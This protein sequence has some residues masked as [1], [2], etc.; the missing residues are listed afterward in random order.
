MPRN[1]PGTEETRKAIHQA[2]RGWNLSD[3][4]D[5]DFFDGFL[6]LRVSGFRAGLT[7]T[8]KRLLVKQSI[9]D[10]LGQLKE[11]QPLQAEILSRRFLHDEPAQQIALSVSVSQDHLNRRQREAIESLAQIWLEKEELA[12]ADQSENLLTALPPS[13]YERLF[14]TEQIQTRLLDLLRS[15]KANWLIA[16]TG[17]GGIGKTA[18]ADSVVRAMLM[19]TL[20]I[21]VIWLR[22]GAEGLNS[23]R[24]G[25]QLMTRL[26][27]HFS[28]EDTPSLKY[29]ESLR[30][31]FKQEAYLV[32]I[33]NLESEVQ[34]LKWL[35]E[36]QDFANPSKFML[37]GRMLPSVFANMQIIKLGE[38]SMQAA[39]DF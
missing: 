36:L 7:A 28:M 26:V 12:R 17:L 16:L 10:C 21:Q 3:Q 25:D 5:L 8:K 1:L 37:T 30:K 19:E 18:L 4:K 23:S 29:R 34:D 11:Q 39:T 27:Q 24:F 15:Q 6:M 33:D 14:G 35:Y 31:I 22:A 13:N 9:E 2:L 38:L 20:Y 32:I